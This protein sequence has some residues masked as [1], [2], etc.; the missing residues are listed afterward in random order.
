M[1]QNS[2]DLNSG[3]F[4]R[5]V[6]ASRSKFTALADRRCHKSKGHT[7]N[8][9]EFPFLDHLLSDYPKVEEKIIR[10]SVMTTGAAWKSEEAGPN[11][12]LRWVML[13]P[14]DELL[15]YGIHM[16]KL[17]PQVVRKLREKAA[18]YDSCI[19][20]AMWLTYIVYQMPDAPQ[21]PPP[22]RKYLERIFGEM[23]FN[24]TTC[25]VCLLPLSFALF[26]EARRGKAAIETCHKDPRIHSPE[27][28]GFSHRECNI[29]QG[30]K[31]LDQFYD[32]VQG[33]ISRAMKQNSA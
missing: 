26:G 33:I 20:V 14:D 5:N 21:P 9:Q 10:D 32:W 18:D 6:I 23:A 1:V 15:K 22:I 24:R 12:I 19:R 28:V 29:A 31:T 3:L 25:C 7:G 17:K 8:C 11:R 27:N 13:L 4:C 2:I 30:D 16:A